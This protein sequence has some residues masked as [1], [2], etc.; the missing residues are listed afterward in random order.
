M[1]SSVPVV[2]ATKALPPTILVQPE[3]IDL[4][5]DVATIGR[6]VWLTFWRNLIV[7]EFP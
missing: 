6:G 1:A 4:T 5:G 7:Y 2:M 3:Q